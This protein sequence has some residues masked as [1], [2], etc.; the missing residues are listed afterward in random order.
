[1]RLPEIS[2]FVLGLLGVV[3]LAACTTFDGLV[4]DATLGDGSTNPDCAP[5][6]PAE[7][8]P[9]AKCKGPAD[10]ESAICGPDGTCATPTSTDGVKNGSET[11]IDCGGG[12]PTSAPKCAA[13]KTCREATDCVWG[14]CTGGICEGHKPGRQDG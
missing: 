9:G 8:Q 10:C 12:S 11:D 13:G 6:C 2:P 1:M 7:H 4:A 3:T 5:T 14:Y